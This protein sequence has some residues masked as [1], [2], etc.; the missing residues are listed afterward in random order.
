VLNPANETLIEPGMVFCLETP[1]Y[2][3]GWGGMMCEDTV[4]VTEDGH[5]RFT[6]SDRELQVIER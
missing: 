3:L 6:I 1:Y 2:E 5:R 4:I